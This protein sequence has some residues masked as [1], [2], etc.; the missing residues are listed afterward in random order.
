MRREIELRTH[1]GTSVPI[2][3]SDADKKE[4]A[5]E[6]QSAI[7]EVLAFKILTCAQEK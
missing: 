7:N 3:L 5:Y 2:A 1:K 4:I 6:F